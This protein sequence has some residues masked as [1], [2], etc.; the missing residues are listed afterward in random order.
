MAFTSIQTGFVAGELSPSVWGRTDLAKYHLGSSTMRNF[1]VNYR[2]GAASRAGL[3]YVGKCLQPATASSNPP[4]DINFQFNINQG[5][6]L[7]F[8]DNPVSLS[9]NILGT[10]S[11]TGG[12]VKLQ[13]G[14]TANLINN[15]TF[16]VSG[17]T[18]TIEANGTWVIQIVDATHV[19]LVG[20]VYAHAWGGGGVL[21][22]LPG[23]LRIKSMGAYVTEAPIAISGITQAN[24]SVFSTA[25]PHGLTVGDWVYSAHSTG[26]TNY[27]GLT[28]IVHTVPSNNAFTV[29]DLF[30]NIVN[31]TLFN[32]YT[33]N[34]TFARIYTVPSPYASADLQYLKFTESTDTM[35]LCCLNQTTNQE[36]PSYELQR[37]STPATIGQYPG[38]VWVFTPDTFA[39]PIAAPT[40]VTAIPQ[41]STTW[42]T[43]YSYVV[44]AV[45]ADTGAES[46]ASTPITIQ[47]NDINIFAGSNTISWNPVAGASNYNVYKATPSY[48]APVA[49]GALYGFMA[50]TQ[51][52]T[53]TDSNIIA[54]ETKVP[55]VHT[56]PFARGQI[57][58]V[59][60]TAAGVGYT[61]SNIGYTINSTTGTG[62]VLA[63][64]VTA[65]G[66]AAFLV[67]DAGQ[68]YLPTDTIT[69][70]GG[71]SAIGSISFSYFAA[72]AQ[73]DTITLGGTVWTFVQPPVVAAAQS[74]CMSTQTGLT[75]SACL[76]A[77]VSNLNQS[78]DVN[79]SKCLY[80]LSGTSTGFVINIIYKTSGT[81]GNAFTLAVSL[82]NGGATTSGATLT[83]G[84]TSGGATASLVVG[85]ETG[86]YPAVPA[87]YQQRRAYGNTLNQPDTYFMSQPGAYSNMDAGIPTSAD[88]A[89][90]GTP[91]SEQ[92]NGIQWMVPMPG[93]LVVMTGKRAWQ[94]NGGNSAA[95]TPADQDANP[96]A[97]NGCSAIVQPIVINYDILYVQA[98]NSI[99]RDLSY[100]FFVNIY[101][102][103]DLTVLS[104]Q[105]FDKHTILQ[106]AYAE[107]PNKLIWGVRDDGIML[108]L[109]Y[110]KEQD[111]YGW[112]RHDTN[113]LFVSVCSITELPVDAVYTIVKRWIVGQNQWAYYS[114]RMDNRQWAKVETAYC[115]DAG[116]QYPQTFPL[117]VLTPSAANGTA[118]ISDAYITVGGQNY[119]A[120]IVNAVDP[121]G[122]GTGATFSVTLTSGAITG[123]T[124]LTQGQNYTPGTELVITD[125][126]GFGAQ[127]QSV[128][129]NN[130][131]FTA[132]SAVFN[133]GMIGN[134]IRGGH[135]K[136]VIGTYNSP[137]QVV[138]NVTI[139]ISVTLPND[140][141]NLPVPFPSGGWSIGV[142][143][144]TV[145]G[146]NHLEGM[147]V[148]GLGDGGVIPAQT[149]VNG[150]VTLA[151]PASYITLGLAFTPQLQTLY[152]DPPSQQSVVQGKRK[153]IYRVV[154]RMEATR[155]ISVG[156][157]QVDASTQPNQAPA[158]WTNM[159]EIKQ[160]NINVNANV[161]IPLFT[162]DLPIRL[163]ATW[164]RGGQVAIQQNYPLPA[165][166]LAIMPDYQIGD[167][168][169]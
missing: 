3:A 94:V 4:R 123:I 139:P 150:T 41:S 79:V 35:T 58:Q 119:T 165:N 34:G 126:T 36:Y 85:P 140:P 70:T 72:L 118:N 153:N 92:I 88:D 122:T 20:S 106:W 163:P 143:T 17:V 22:R 12:A 16:T 6:V 147:Q 32:A 68:N 136:A 75:L 13:V 73:Y 86:T 53:V 52:T 99:V 59:L 7:E 67:E 47:N 93:G 124:V 78:T 135:G 5:Y 39:A 96:Q 116:L 141:N 30:G 117:A 28:W 111:V 160:R 66:L 63:P 62:A 155:G 151:S 54:D 83:G 1:Q 21:T 64:I 120:P 101:T 14:S 166:I 134:V 162:G 109:T 125:P 43:Y 55:P 18:G 138:A 15:T 115:V 156:T 25:V 159:K 158:P 19:R 31:A 50:S 108:C 71:G 137:T 37:T 121:F 168:P 82:A 90:T 45:D 169:G 42:S 104:N 102:G 27:N 33:G 38:G 61:Q 161:P 157:N 132:S 2:G 69:M 81:G 84:A 77:F 57:E 60:P 164:R 76:S 87:Y 98:K 91:W 130:V 26:M 149:V 80:S 127:L 49:V 105:L 95:I 74:L 133:S 142:P 145:T 56:N 128:V 103:T 129:T 112:S 100:N 144:Q 154:C 114:E 46:V 97:S 48:N 9:L 24:P 65:N 152:L 23:Y 44:T 107:E 131:T 146:L 51:G 29:T 89:I 8:G 40:G 110:L 10:S 167:S 113:G 11:G 148:V